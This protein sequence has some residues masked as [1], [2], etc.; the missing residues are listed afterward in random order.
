MP[1]DALLL[2]DRQRLPETTGQKSPYAF[3]GVL[4]VGSEMHHPVNEKKCCQL[5]QE[6]V[7]VSKGI[8]F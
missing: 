5:L 7:S 2:A 8:S 3:Q 6:K 4:S 1:D